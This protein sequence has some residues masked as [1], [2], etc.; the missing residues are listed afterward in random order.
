MLMNW[1]KNFI[2]LEKKCIIIKDGDTKSEFSIKKDCI[3]LYTPLECIN[4]YFDLDLKTMP[5]SKEEFFEKTTIKDERPDNYV[6]RI[7]ASHAE[8][9]IDINN[10]LVKEV[11]ELLNLEK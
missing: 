6:K 7:L 11:D 10:P 9:F 3:E 4:E 2:N 1:K 5:N 8:E